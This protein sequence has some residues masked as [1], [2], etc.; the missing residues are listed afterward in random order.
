MSLI[1]YSNVDHVKLVEYAKPLSNDSLCE[2]K[3]ILSFNNIKDVSSDLF[4]YIH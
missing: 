2:I 4:R 3:R 1:S